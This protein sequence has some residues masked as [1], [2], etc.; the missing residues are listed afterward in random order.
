MVDYIIACAG[1]EVVRV[2]G[3]SDV[4]ERVLIGAY[5]GTYAVCRL[6]VVGEWAG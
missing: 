6:Y 1:C 5:Y 3:C 4:E 2:D